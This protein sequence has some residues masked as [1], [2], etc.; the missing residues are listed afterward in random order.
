MRAA[1]STS[2]RYLD[3]LMGKSFVDRLK[4]GEILIA[5]GATATNYQHLAGVQAADLCSRP[6]DH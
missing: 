1:R 4:A 6:G 5:D 2:S 3:R